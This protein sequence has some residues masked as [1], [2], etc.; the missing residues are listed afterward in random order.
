MA[1][2]WL[3]LRRARPMAGRLS[4]CRRFL[5]FILVLVLQQPSAA[6]NVSVSALT[7]NRAFNRNFLSENKLR[8]KARLEVRRVHAHRADFHGEIFNP[9]LLACFQT[10]ICRG[11]RCLGAAVSRSLRHPRHRVK[12][13]SKSV[14][15]LLPHQSH[16]SY[17]S[18]SHAVRDACR[19]E[20]DPRQ[21]LRLR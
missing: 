21:R 1:R 19:G 8:L 14:K 20:R 4:H 10:K 12:G 11:S 15:P 2:C 18:H 6:T 7:S 16:Q 13:I 3:C 5:V 17:P 9:S